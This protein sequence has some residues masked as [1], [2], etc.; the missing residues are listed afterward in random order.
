HNF[1][2]DLASGEQA[3]V[4]LTAPAVNG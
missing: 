4:A 1:P 2:L 3:P